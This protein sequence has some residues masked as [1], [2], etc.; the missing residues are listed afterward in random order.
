[1]EINAQVWRRHL[2]RMDYGDAVITFFP[3]SF[4]K[5]ACRPAVKCSLVLLVWITLRITYLQLTLNIACSRLLVC[6][7]ER[8][9]NKT[10]TRTRGIW[11]RMPF[12]APNCFCFSHFI[13]VLLFCCFGF[14]SVVNIHA[15]CDICIF[16]VWKLY[17]NK[18]HFSQWIQLHC[19]STT[20]WETMQIY[21]VHDI[22][23]SIMSNNKSLHVYI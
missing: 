12:L 10:S 1:M 20:H 22:E 5:P 8:K 7:D 3:Q 2:L 4:I 18:C 11:G 15:S 14:Y 6:G 13:S 23:V 17:A 21:I 19:V 16:H 9:G